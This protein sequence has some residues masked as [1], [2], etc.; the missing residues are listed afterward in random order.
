MC[1][2]HRILCQIHQRHIHPNLLY[3]FNSF[4]R[5]CFGIIHTVQW[6][7]FLQCCLC[8]FRQSLSWD[9]FQYIQHQEYQSN[10]ISK[11]HKC[12]VDRLEWNFILFS[13]IKSS[14]NDYR[15]FPNRLI[16]WIFHAPAI[17]S[18]TFLRFQFATEI[19]KYFKLYFF[20][21]IQILAKIYQNWNE[22]QSCQLRNRIFLIMPWQSNT[23]N[24]W[25]NCRNNHSR[26]KF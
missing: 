13:S 19:G 26:T 14:F 8:C 21:L 18:L 5:S 20:E 1:F 4:F 6:Y 2:G 9:I 25:F 7:M 16:H 17:F 22:H 12:Y 23:E 11:W 10:F 15:L 3:I 24:H